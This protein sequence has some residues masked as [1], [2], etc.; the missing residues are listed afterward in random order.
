MFICPLY[1]RCE[2]PFVCCHKTECTRLWRDICRSQQSQSVNYTETRIHVVLTSFTHSHTAPGVQS[3]FTQPQGTGNDESKLAILYPHEPDLSPLWN[4]LSA[5]LMNLIPD[6][7]RFASRS[8]VKRQ[9][10][11][12]L[13]MGA[14]KIG[15]FCNVA[16][17]MSVG[18][19]HQFRKGGS[20]KKLTMSA[21][22]GNFHDQQSHQRR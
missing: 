21:W 5:V 2:T 13:W 19:K 4:F 15:A 9:E 16:S 6:C 7:G 10:W 3:T 1:S 22:W 8:Q 17:A 11:L 12:Q 14:P 18:Q 20:K